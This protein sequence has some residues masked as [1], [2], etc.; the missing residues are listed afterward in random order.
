MPNYV[1][2][3][4]LMYY[5]VSYISKGTEIHKLF[6]KICEN[7]TFLDCTLIAS[8]FNILYLIQ[9]LFKIDVKIDFLV[10]GM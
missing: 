4:Y 2:V 7:Y 6:Y 8:F 10:F 1:C 3:M 9:F 5:I